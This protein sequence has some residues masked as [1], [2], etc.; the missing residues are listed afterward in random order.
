MNSL[1]LDF[2]GSRIKLGLVSD[3][4]VMVSEIVPIHTGLQM[5]E[6]LGQIFPAIT[7]LLKQSVEPVKGIGIAFPGLVD[8]EKKRIVSINDKYPDAGTF[9][10]GHWAREMYGLP[11][12]IENDANAALLGETTFGCAAGA[13]DAVML[14]LGTGVGTA[15]LM[16]GRLVRGKHFQAG[17]MGGH[18]VVHP[19]GRACTCG[20]HGCVEAYASTWALPNLAREQPDFPQSGLSTETMMDFKILEKWVNRRDPLALRLLA[21]MNA[22]WG[23]CLVSLVHAYDPEVLILSGGV[24]K[25]GDK[26]VTPLS[27]AV[28]KDVCAGSVTLKILVAQ[29]PEQSVLLGLHK[30]ILEKGC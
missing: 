5:N 12:E 16:D 30:R 20:G 2:G 11:V 9:D 10:F 14:I 1:C 24:I 4:R 18:F 28:R 15:A 6:A 13:T 22:C 23:A 27:E 26:V 29:N 8:P 7:A 17:C 19:G 25:F 21:E 3:G